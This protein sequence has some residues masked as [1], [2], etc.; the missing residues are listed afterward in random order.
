MGVSSPSGRPTAQRQYPSRRPALVSAPAKRQ[1]QLQLE[2]VLPLASVFSASSPAAQLRLVTFSQTLLGLE[3]SNLHL[4]PAY[5]PVPVLD[6]SHESR[7]FHLPLP[8][9]PAEWQ[10]KD[11]GRTNTHHYPALTPS[12]SRLWGRWGVD[13]AAQQL[14]SLCRIQVSRGSRESQFS[15]HLET[16]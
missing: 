8:A 10:H 6:Y 4:P 9:S 7:F 12:S 1:Q 14:L 5:D 15:Q 16:A 3:V 11:K 13:R 2:L